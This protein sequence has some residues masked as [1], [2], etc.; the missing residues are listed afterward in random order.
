MSKTRGLDHDEAARTASPGTAAPSSAQNEDERLLRSMGYAPNERALL[1]LLAT[2]GLLCAG[3]WLGARA[4]FPGPPGAS[5][6]LMGEHDP[7]RPSTTV[8]QADES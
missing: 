8:L 1:V 4:S 3:W 2:S 6:T 7:V 5:S